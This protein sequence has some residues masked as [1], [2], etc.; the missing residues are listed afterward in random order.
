MRHERGKP[1]AGEFLP[2]KLFVIFGCGVRDL[3]TDLRGRALLEFRELAQKLVEICP[4]RLGSRDDR[5]ESG[6]QNACGSTLKY[7]AAAICDCTLNVR[8]LN[9]ARYLSGCRI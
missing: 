9:L 6:Q 4:W 1:L 8:H 2:G 3:R 5:G 7:K